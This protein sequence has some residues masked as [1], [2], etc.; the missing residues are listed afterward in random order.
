MCVCVC[1][2]PNM[3]VVGSS[4]ISWFPGMWLRYCLSDFEIVPF[5]PIITGITL[6]SYSTCAEF[7]L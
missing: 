3:A 1:A 4:L 2:V 7:I 6:L 5:A